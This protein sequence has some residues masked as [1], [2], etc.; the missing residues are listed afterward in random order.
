MKQLPTRFRVILAVVFLLAGATP[1]AGALPAAAAAAPAV[2]TAPEGP[3][4]LA[5]QLVAAGDSA[6]GGRGWALLGRQLF[7]TDDGGA[8]WRDI[9]PPRLDA[10]EIRAASFADPLHGWV[11]TTASAASGNLSYTM[12]RTADGGQTWQ[13]QPLALFAADEAAGM[14]GE[15]YLQIIDANT[16]WLEVKQATSSNFNLGTL[17]KTVDGGAQWTRLS[18]PTGAPAHFTSTQDGEFDATDTGNGSYITQDGGQDW[19]ALPG[20][21]T[22]EASGPNGP[23]GERLSALSMAT[24]RAGWARSAQ[25]Q[26]T[27]GVCALITKL[28]S[29]ANSGH[30]WTPVSLPGGQTMLAQ[31]FP[32]AASAAPGQSIG[33]LR[34][35][36]DG[37]GFDNCKNDGSLPATGDMQNWYSFSPYGVWNLYIGGSS[38]ANCGT[39]TRAYV[40]ALARQGWLFIPTWVGPQ[41]PCS[42]VVPPEK[43]MSID[44][45][46]AYSQGVTEAFL[47]RNV[48][49][50]LGLTLSD[51]SGSVIYFDVENY[52][53]N[54]A[55]QDAVKAFISGWSGELRTTGDQAGVYGAPCGPSLSDFAQVTH[56][57]DLIW[58]AAWSYPGYDPSASVWWQGCGLNNT[59]WTNHQRLRQYAGGH[60]E[61]WAGVQF[62]IDSDRIVGSLSTV[63]DACTPAAG[64]AAFFVYPNY[65]GQCVVKGLGGYS[66][67]AALGL[68][69]Q[70]ISSLRVSS[71]ITV[72]LCQGENYAQACSVF[73]SDQAD[74]GA[75]AV[76]NSQA[77]S[78]LIVSGTL[79]YNQH[80]YLPLL[81]LNSGPFTQLNNGGFEAGSDQWSANSAAGRT[82][83]V[84]EGV[85]ASASVSPHSGSWA[86]WLGD[87]VG[88]ALTETASLQQ[89][90]LIPPGASYLGYWQWIVSGEAACYFDVATVWVNDTV[91]DSY[92]LC[93]SDSTLGWVQHTVNLSAYAGSTVM[94]KF[95][96]QTDK[97]VD[98]N[99]FLDDLAFQSG[100]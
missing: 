23:N 52:Q 46:S 97:T 48:A 77:S 60:T 47:A 33:G 27:A 83:I 59:L 19:T 6:T 35:T 63:T 28:L 21:S 43:R 37:H 76:G 1:G 31:N 40:Q 56:V 9:T 3:N 78:A 74:L 11:V 18:L 88:N 94:L 26:C 5:F 81:S 61:N 90:V 98:S 39:L 29:T 75:T 55:C 51:L 86:A 66:T 87:G 62:N 50:N 65:G 58:I 72:T 15:V 14:A 25:G 91:V 10:A 99:L 71:G 8:H 38:R 100:P 93:A 34:V 20:P 79:K 32:A 92:G 41:A 13:A 30:T 7:W 12:A 44:P 70:S 4:L 89:T 95:Q 57:P 73:G 96:V 54:Q 36:Y 42:S 17:F 67:N 64:Q 68:P 82:L 69:S 2:P 85:L 49:H 80:I 24:P 84:P 22:S 16:G 53:G 45:G